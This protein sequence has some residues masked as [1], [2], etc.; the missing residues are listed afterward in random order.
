LVVSFFYS[1]VVQFFGNIIVLIQYGFLSVEYIAT[2]GRGGI[3]HPGGGGCFNVLVTN[4]FNQTN[5]IQHFIFS[6]NRA[7]CVF[8]FHGTSVGF[9]SLLYRVH[10]I[11]NI[12]TT[13][14]L[15]LR[16]LTA[17]SPCQVQTRRDKVST[18]ETDAFY[19]A[20]PC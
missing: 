2:R 8:L 14:L 9:S 17:V 18:L 12:V 4:I 19:R 3:F 6:N 10:L 16:N 5:Y 11:Y 15:E 1:V 7:S 13:D 20:S